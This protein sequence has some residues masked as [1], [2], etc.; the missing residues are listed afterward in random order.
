[1]PGQYYPPCGSP[2]GMLLALAVGIRERAVGWIGPR[3]MSRT[4]GLFLWLIGPLM[5]LGASYLRLLTGSVI[6]SLIGRTLSVFAFLPMS[7]WLLRS[8]KDT[9]IDSGTDQG[10]LPN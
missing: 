5:I 8:V 6:L 1:M 3:R 4:M 2:W 7:Y 9:L 10:A